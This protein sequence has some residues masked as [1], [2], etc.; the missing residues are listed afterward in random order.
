MNL[1]R[2][3]TS[4]YSCSYSYRRVERRKQRRNFIIWDRVVGSILL[5]LS[6]LI[7]PCAGSGAT[8]RAAMELGR[9]SYG[10]EVSKEFYRKSKEEMLIYTPD[11]QMDITDFQEFMPAEA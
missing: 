2:D 1:V 3:T 9:S 7:D 5:L 4:D 6:F 10:F 8:L 11:P